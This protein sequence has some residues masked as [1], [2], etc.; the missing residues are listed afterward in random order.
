LTA[1]QRDFPV[2]IDGTAEKS[3]SPNFGVVFAKEGLAPGPHVL[4]LHS[5]QDGDTDVN[6]LPQDFEI[7]SINILMGDGDTTW[8]LSCTDGSLEGRL[9][10]H[11]RTLAQAARLEPTD[12]NF[13][14]ARYVGVAQSPTFDG[15]FAI[16]MYV[17]F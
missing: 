13:T 3:D 5:I 8:A 1:Q 16:P 12:T 14:F 4:K 11:V 15:G 7:N 9:S 2:T 10:P 17:D 6:G